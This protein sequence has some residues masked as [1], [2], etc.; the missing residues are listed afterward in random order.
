MVLP[1]KLLSANASDR[2]ED[3]P[4]RKAGQKSEVCPRNAAS[5]RSYFLQPTK[6]FDAE[7]G[8]FGKRADFFG[9]FVFIFSVT[10]LHRFRSGFAFVS[11]G[12][13]RV[14]RL[15]VAD[16]TIARIDADV[17]A[18]AVRA[19]A[20]CD[21]RGRSWVRIFF[22]DSARALGLLRG[23]SAHPTRIAF[24]ICLFRQF[25]LVVVVVRFSLFILF[26]FFI[27]VLIVVA[28]L[29]VFV[30]VL[31]LRRLAIILKYW[32]LGA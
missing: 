1:E 30:A 26:R 5:K 27:V 20:A 25:F 8:R 10:S 19:F 31:V 6:M 29:V 4:C 24:L 16:C 13:V 7:L 9:M 22:F 11:C 2:C 21:D 28:V 3:V 15:G 17:I 18:F 12:C 32:H 23:Y 14:R